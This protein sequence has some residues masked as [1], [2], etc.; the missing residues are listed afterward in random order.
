MD[1]NNKPLPGA[2]IEITGL[3][4]T[5]RSGKDG[6]YWRLLTA[7]LYQVTASAEHYEKV[8]KE[9]RVADALKATVVSFRLPKGKPTPKK[10]MMF[11][12]M[13]HLPLIAMASLI[14]IIVALTL[15]GLVRFLRRHGRRKDFSKRNGRNAYKDEYEREVAMKSFNSKA[16]L[17][18]EYSDDSEEDE[19][20]E[21]V[22]Q[23]RSYRKS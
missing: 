10:S 20:E 17:R 23:G 9:V 19:L 14:G 12:G 21:Y 18:N 8:T 1:E 2:T 3:A 6:D 15:F 11:F 4:H 7:G 16:L 22:V 5:V 13:K